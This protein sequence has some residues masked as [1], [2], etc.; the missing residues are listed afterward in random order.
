MQLHSPVLEMAMAA[1]ESRTAIENN[2][3]NKPAA[4]YLY[5]DQKLAS[6]TSESALKALVET[7]GIESMVNGP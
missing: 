4:V 7:L 6:A 5:G 3:T 1:P 2:K